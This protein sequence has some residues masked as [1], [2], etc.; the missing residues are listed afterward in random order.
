MVVMVWNISKALTDDPYTSD[1]AMS[2]CSS[3][4]IIFFHWAADTWE[5]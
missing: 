4:V 3:R 1:I 5:L 2:H